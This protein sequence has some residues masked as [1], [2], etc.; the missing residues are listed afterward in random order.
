M[1]TI[2]PELRGALSLIKRL[3][4][5]G[6]VASAGHTMASYEEA[7]AGIKAEATTP[8][9]LSLFIRERAPLNSGAI[10]IIFSVPSEASSIISII[11]LEGRII[12]SDRI[13]PFF[14][15]LINGPSR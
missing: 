11:L 13:I 7:K 14:L 8:D 15:I 4:K 2:A 1:M 6:V 9:F 12:P 10:V 5:S 3:K